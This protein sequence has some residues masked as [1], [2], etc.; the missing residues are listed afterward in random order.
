MFKL[1]P[2]S[3]IK[4]NFDKLLEFNKVNK[5]NDIVIIGAGAAG[6]EVA[7]ALDENLKEE[8]LK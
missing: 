5:N 2:I 8:T 3:S 7:L 1:K 4:E 6:F